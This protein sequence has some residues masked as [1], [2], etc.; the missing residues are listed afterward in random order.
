LLTNDWHVTLAA[1]RSEQA[2]A[3]AADFA[4]LAHH[5]LS[6]IPFAALSAFELPPF[7][8]VNTT[9]LGMSPHINQSPWPPAVPFPPSAAVYD[10][11][12][13]P[14]QTLLVQQARAAGLPAINGLGMLVGQAA[15]AFEIWTGQ[16]PPRDVLFASVE[17]V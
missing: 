17:D 15:L 5:P 2:Q 4:S 16:H 8:I 9:P 13:N 1:R 11:V 6:V 10:L 14:R 7:L 3:L 12:Y